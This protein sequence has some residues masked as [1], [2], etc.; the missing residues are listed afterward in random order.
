[1]MLS[2]VV[3]PLD[4]AVVWKNG[5]HTHM[6]SG[7]QMTSKLSWLGKVKLSWLSKLSTWLH[8]CTGGLAD[9]A[10][11]KTKGQTGEA[12]R[13]ATWLPNMELTLDHGDHGTKPCG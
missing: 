10:P 6:A 9:W 2:S 5:G 3:L 8:A 12:Y 13:P 11:E 7:E 4:A 1:M